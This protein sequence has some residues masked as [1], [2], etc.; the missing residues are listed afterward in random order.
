MK[1]LKAINKYFWK[2][3]WRFLFGILFIVLS[4]YF[5]IL[6]PQLT[7]FVI[8]EV[9]LE[10]IQKN[11]PGHYSERIGEV[12][13]KQSNYDI[14][15]KEL[16]HQF[17]SAELGF[18]QKIVWTGI[19]LLSLAILSGFFLFLM[20]QT[21]IVMSRHIEFDQKNEVFG[22]YLKLD[23]NFYKTHSTGDLMN[24]IAEDV[25]RVRMYTGPALMYFINLAVTIGFSVYFMLATNA[26]LTLYVLAPLPLLAITIYFVNNII[27]RKSERI[28]GLLSDLTTNAQESYSGIRV[29]KSFV[30]EKAMFSFFNKNA[31]AYKENAIGL[32]KVEAIY[33]PSMALLIGL[34]TLLTIMI[35]GIYAIRGDQSITIGTIAEF[36]MYVNMLTFPVS[37]IGWTASMIQR[38]AASQKRLNEFLDTVPAIEEPVAAIEPSLDG[39]IDF[40]NVDFVYPNTG[41]HA[42]KSFDLH[43]KRGEKIAI[44]G[45]TGSGKTT[46]AQLLLRMYDPSSGNIEIDKTDLRKMD[47]Q[48]LRKQISYVPQDVFLF[49]DSITSNISFGLDGAP[50]MSKVQLAAR[51]ASVEKEIAGFHDQYNTMIGERGVTLSGGQKQRISIARALIK[52]PHIVVFDD[53][54]S[55]VDARTEKEILGNLNRYLKDKTAIII[56][57]RIFTLF[58]FDQI[59]VMEEGKMVEKGTHNELLAQNGYYSYLYE[60]QLLERSDT[61]EDN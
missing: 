19:V 11:S 3:R 50:D 33:F 27:N 16:I 13:K 48:G 18:G 30:Q 2:Y 55:A 40:N 24:R 35:G 32:A 38:A 31:E 54:L 14:G 49:S 34:S 22:H 29:I 45:H 42:L 1:H 36:V 37:A 10:L 7:G 60:Q 58:D 44:I 9:Q 12:T 61:P 52:D 20:R 25:S 41:I 46:I 39:V 59:I 5:K 47:L 17:T 51:H 53:C 43:V 4:N 21:I 23:S 56:T 28:Q 57:H 8:D 26:M 15:V 6:S